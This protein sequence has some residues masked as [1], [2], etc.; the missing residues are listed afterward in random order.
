SF[1]LLVA[2]SDESTYP[3]LRLFALGDNGKSRN[4]FIS[5]IHTNSWKPYL[6]EYYTHGSRWN[7]DA[8]C[9]HTFIIP[10]RHESYSGLFYDIGFRNINIFVRSEEHT[11]ALQS[12]ENL[13]CRLL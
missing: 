5:A 8:L 11:S 12:R 6:L 13:V 9:S 3:G 7:Y 4:I 2:R 10:N 1:P